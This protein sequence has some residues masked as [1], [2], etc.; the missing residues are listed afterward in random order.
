MKTSSPLPASAPSWLTESLAVLDARRRLVAG[1]AVAIVFLGAAVA[2]IA[3]G[4]LPP[5]IIVGVAVGIAAVLLSVA[6]ALAVDAADLIVRGSRHVNA[7]GGKVSARIGR[8]H[9]D[10]GPLL[11]A[12]SRHA[13]DGRVRL[14][15][16]P[17]SRAAGVPGARAN[18]VAQA[19]ARTGRKVLLC[20]MS[21][22]ETAAVGLSDVIAGDV[23]LTEAVRFD[24]ELYLARLAVG[25]DPEAALAGLAD[26]IHALPSDLEVLVIALPPLSEPGVLAAASALDVTMLLV[27]VGRTERVDLIAS[28]DAIDAASLAAELVLV[29]PARSAVGAAE[30][31]GDGDVTIRTSAPT[32]SVLGLDPAVD[33]DPFAGDVFSED[34]FSEDDADDVWRDTA[35]QPVVVDEDAFVDT[36]TVKVIEARPPAEPASVSDPVF[37]EPDEDDEVPAAPAAATS[38]TGTPA[39]GADL[40]LADLSESV[41]LP[42]ADPSARFQVPL[43]TMPSPPSAVSEPEPE[44]EPDVADDSAVVADVDTDPDATMG[45]PAVRIIESTPSPTSEA[46]AESP[47]E[48]LEP[49]EEPEITPEPA[50]GP[51]DTVPIDLVEIEESTAP[52]PQPEPQVTP[53]PAAPAPAPAAAAPAP[54][55]APTGADMDPAADAAARLSAALHQLATQSWERDDA[56]A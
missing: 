32:E 33:D 2:L 46:S 49:I 54:A 42:V 36:P 56:R 17:A 12:T 20:D 48:A 6:L 55:P 3:P 41:D 18:A 43:G 14:A 27:E 51:D 52:E 23:P 44:S 47:D 5:R 29:D 22:G 30:P 35:R 25:S 24:S 16:A 50:P 8:D 7:A 15:L 53:E 11:S 13:S 26:W 38:D 45:I 40:G 21:R 39:A 34:A 9:R 31:T 10:V 4:L 1:T 28:L 37:D 19:L